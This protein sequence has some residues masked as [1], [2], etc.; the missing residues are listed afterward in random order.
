MAL[1]QMKPAMGLV[2]LTES[3]PWVHRSKPWGFTT[4]SQESEL[5]PIGKMRPIRSAAGRLDRLAA[6]DSADR[7]SDSG[8]HL[9]DLCLMIISKHGG[10]RGLV[11]GIHPFTYS[12]VIYPRLIPCYTSNGSN[13]GIT[14]MIYIAMMILLIDHLVASCDAW[15]YGIVHWRNSELVGERPSH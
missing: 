5:G 15:N 13:G 2:H 3:G 8:V 1:N 4:R 7:R 9:V 6:S 10:F 12:M 14:S 11:P